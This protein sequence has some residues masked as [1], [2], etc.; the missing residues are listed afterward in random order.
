MFMSSYPL[1]GVFVSTLYLVFFVLWV[2]LV[3]HV[4]AD[5][6][7]SHDL[8]G[9]AKAAWVLFIIVL[10]LL[11]CLV[12]LIARGSKMHERELERA[13]MHQKAFEDYIRK[14]ANSKGE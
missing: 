1:L 6:F 11:G 7:K 4:L 14:V 2:L 9:V 8:S 12:Y 5:I 13:Q 3:F 10:P